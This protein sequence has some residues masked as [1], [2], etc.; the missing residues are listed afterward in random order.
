MDWQPTTPELQA[1]EDLCRLFRQHGG[2]SLLVGGWVR[3]RLLGLESR[4]LDLEVYGIPAADVQALLERHHAVDLTGKA[5]GI[6]KLKSWPIDVSIPR[7]ESKRGLG[8]RGFLVE[9]D[10]GLPPDVAARRRDFTINAMSFD[11][12]TGE[13]VDPFGG[14]E[15]LQRRILRH[16][17]DQFAE[18][19]LRVLRGMQFCAR[20]RLD[21]APETVALCRGLDMEGLAPERVFEEWSKLILKG[22]EPSRGLRFLRDSGWVRFFPEV[23]AL[24]GCK[25]DPYWHPEG[26]VW[27]HTCHCLDAFAAARTGDDWEDLVV[28]FAALCHDLGKP[29][30]TATTG[31]GIRSLGHSEAGLE[32]TRS[33]LAGMSRHQD[34]VDQVCPLVAEHLRP[35]E[36][37]QASASA[38]AVRRLASR[39]GRIDRL[40]RVAEADQRGRPPIEVGEFEAGKW[41]LAK[42]DAEGIMACRP[43]PLI[44]G[45]DL[46][47]RGME[48]GAPMG[49]FLRQC[50]EDQLYGLFDSEETVRTYLDERLG[51]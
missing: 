47:A 2:R 16:T 38:A 50:Y 40:V 1:T 51:S 27:T 44:R 19:P 5:F 33:F 12:L 35:V 13:I 3:D 48:P 6:L 49:E 10:P 14:A 36:L 31:A 23:E 8:H 18:D 46:V 11:P 39:V 4:D 41:L 30:T 21:A 9:S 15:D 20:F 17:S 7:R 34:L 26:D 28:G 32:P 45:R 37:F 29:L 25:Q 24:I 22:E 42:A 43:V